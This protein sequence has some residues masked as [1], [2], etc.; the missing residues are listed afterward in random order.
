MTGDGTPTAGSRTRKPSPRIPTSRYG[1]AARRG[2]ALLLGHHR[3]AEGHPAALPEGGPGQALPVMEFVKA[4]FALPRGH[5]LSVRRRRCTTRRP[6]PACPHRCG[7]GSP[8]GHGA[9]RRRTVAG[10]GRASPGHALP[11]GAD[12]VLRLLRLPAEVRTRA[13]VSSLEVIV[14]AAAPCPVPVKEQMIDWSG[15][16]SSSTTARPRPTGSRS[17]TR[18]SGSPTGA[19]SASRSSANCSSSTKTVPCPT[20]TPARSGSGARPTSST[21]M[22]RTRRAESRD[23]DGSDQ[24]GR[25]RRLRRRRRLPL[26][27]RPQDA[28]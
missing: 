26:P 4:M 25:R 27:H 1:R 20:G 19:P 8:R 3:P 15:R 7:S 11:D 17:A 28:T 18:P 21:S 13:D 6:R 12:D 23:G 9:L 16:S 2:H 5:D 24:H 14:H 22:P 10:P